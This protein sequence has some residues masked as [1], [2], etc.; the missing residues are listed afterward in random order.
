M[1][2]EIKLTIPQQVISRQTGDEM[3]LLDLESGLYFGVDGV[4]QRIWETFAEGR[5]LEEAI[6]VVVAEYE[7]DQAQAQA[8]VIAFVRNLVDRGLLTE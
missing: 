8:D 3:V 1:N 6:A 4:G 2:L 5:N 7:V